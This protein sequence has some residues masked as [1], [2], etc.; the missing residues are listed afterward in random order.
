MKKYRNSQKLLTGKGATH[1]Q[2]RNHLG[3]KTQ[4]P[5]LSAVTGEVTTLKFF[6]WWKT[7]RVCSKQHA[8]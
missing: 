4:I 7:P 6:W 8:S 1:V 3:K 2:N 5:S